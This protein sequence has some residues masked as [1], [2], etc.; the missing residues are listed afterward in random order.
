[1]NERNRSQAVDRRTFVVLATGAAAGAVMA[2]SGTVRAA[3][4]EEVEKAIQ[5]AIGDK[6]P[7]SGEGVIDL[8]VPQIAE[9]GSTVPIGVSV[10]SPMT[11]EDHV[12]AVHIFA[13]GNPNP[14]VVS[15]LFTPM[16]GRA[17][18][19][20][21]MRLAKTQNVV[22]IAETSKGEAYRTEAE[23]KVTIGGCG[24]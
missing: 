2:L 1:M 4:S 12:T 11:D 23:I 19:S 16:S 21:R 14:D 13:L 3:T 18:A 24:G 5:R 10:D 7:K 15:F 20:T 9:N 22:A 6:S 8:E 17:E